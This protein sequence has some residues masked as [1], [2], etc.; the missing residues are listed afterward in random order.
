M[1]IFNMSVYVYCSIV[2][3]IH[4]LIQLLN[5]VV[6]G[7]LCMMVVCVSDLHLEHSLNIEAFDKSVF[8]VVSLFDN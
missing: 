7:T 4:F 1:T 3:E 6:N 2:L 5:S 8:E